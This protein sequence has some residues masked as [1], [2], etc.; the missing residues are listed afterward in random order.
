MRKV[1][2]FLLFALISIAVSLPINLYLSSKFDGIVGWLVMTL[3][4]GTLFAFG[5]VLAGMIVKSRRLCQDFLSTFEILFVLDMLLPTFVVIAF[6]IKSVRE[7]VYRFPTA[8]NIGGG[9]F[10]IVVSIIL[11]MFIMLIVLDIA[12]N[13]DV[14]GFA[15]K[16]CDKV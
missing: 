5:E 6:V 10:L 4:T 11:G 12:L 3:V 14:E 9:V 7:V 2:M 15:R 1:L 8:Y 16:Y 13:A